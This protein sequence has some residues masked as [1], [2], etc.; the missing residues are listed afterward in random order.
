MLWAPVS[1]RIVDK[2]LRYTV[3]K[4]TREILFLPL[5]S[6]IK[7]RAK[8]FVDVTVDRFARAVLALLVLVLIAPWGLALD[9]QRLSFASLFVTVL[10]IAM[11]IIAK[12]GY[13]AAFRNSIDRRDM[14][15]DTVRLNVAD[16]QTVETLIEELADPDEQRV[17]YAIDILESL[18]KR[19]LITPLLLYHES[20]KVRS[21][22]LQA[23]GAVRPDVAQRWLPH[24]QRMLGD[25]DTEVRVAAMSA[26]ANIREESVSDIVRPFLQNEDARLACSAAMVLGRNGDAADLEAAE[27]TLVRVAASQDPAARRGSR[28]RDPAG[29]DPRLRHVLIPLLYDDDPE[30]V[31]EA[32]RSVRAMG[33]SDFL[34]VPT[35]V[36]LLRNRRLKGAAREVLTGYG[37]EVVPVLAHF[38]RDGDEDIWVRRHIPS[39]LASIPTQASMDTLVGALDGEP[40]GFL[41][42]KLLAA[43]DRLHRDQPE[44]T[45][46]RK[47]L[48]ALIL[49]QSTRYYTWLSLHYNLFVRAKLPA[50]SLLAQAL[51]EKTD[52]AVSRIYLLLGMLYPRQDVTAARWAIERGDSKTRASALEYLDNLLTGAVRKRIMP[53]IEDTPL[54]EKVRR[55]NALLSTRPRDVEETLLQLINDEDQM[56]AAA[57]IQCTARHQI[58]AL[59]PDIEHVLAHRDPRDWFVFEAASWALAEQRMPAERVRQLWLEPLPAV[60]LASRLRTLPIF[61]RVSVDELFRLGGTGRQTRYEAGHVLSVEG[62]APGNVQFLLEG[63]VEG[64]SRAGDTRTFEPVSPLGFDEVITG[65]PSEWSLRAKTRAVC[66]DLAVDEWRTLLADNSYLVQGLFRTVREHPAFGRDQ[67]LM[68]GSA[69]SAAELSR[70]TAEGLSPV[71]KVLALQNVGP[72]AEVGAD[73]LLH[74]AN[75]ARRVTFASGETL[76]QAAQIADTLVVIDGELALA[77]PQ[78]PSRA[79]R[80]GDVVGLLESL[81]G[82]PLGADVKAASA[83]I[84]LRLGHAELLEVLGERPALLRQ[85]FARLLGS[86]PAAAARAS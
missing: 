84:A 37:P 57:A 34:F 2:S 64:R 3:D 50:D 30:V 9:W 82:V 65:T 45:F 14:A 46:D 52:R 56:V 6:D 72:F 7:Q 29:V 15:A 4:T 17:L 33:A 35:L 62:Q 24:V 55:G 69:K 22:A 81:A 86:R 80:G 19:N 27:A 25:S 61:A 76:G 47:P 71:E 23:L 5:P 11:A 8:P 63:E 1:A 40:D 21:R 74:V 10:W 38:L 85:L 28:R 59:A 78:G 44:L 20:P 68:E 32:L 41:R 83:G 43:I 49:K 16:L 75:A 58:W 60:E 39:T 54:E 70:L 67:V 48:E 42:F 26:L 73:E 79:A 13:I 18:D 12:R 53:V 77:L 31:E 51:R 36:G 66:L